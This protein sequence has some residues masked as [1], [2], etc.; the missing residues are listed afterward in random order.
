MHTLQQ[1]QSGKLLGTKAL[2]LSCGL[3]QL[4]TEILDL[5]HTLELLDVSGNNLKDLPEWFTKLSNLK[6]AF[7]SNNDFQEFPAVLGRCPKLEMIGFKA[8]KIRSIP[9]GAIPVN[10]RWLILT[11]NQIATL[12]ASIG[13]CARMQKLMLAGNKL[14]KLPRELASCQNLELL[15]IS[16]NE[17]EQLPEWLFTLPRLSWLAFSGNP[18]NPAPTVANRLLEINWG[19]LE[20]MEQLGEGA[21]G[22]ISKALWHQPDSPTPPQQVAVKVF[23]GEVTSDGLPQDEMQACLASGTHPNLVKVLGKISGHPLQKRGLVFALIPEGYRNLGG[24]PSLETCTRDTFASGTVFSIAEILKISSGIAAAA[25]YLHARGI[26]H[27][28]LYAHN[29]LVNANGHPLFG[30]FGAATVYGSP[31]ATHAEALERI[32]VR[33]FG[34][35]LDDLFTHIAPED[36][37]AA[38]VKPLLQLQQDCL[39]PEILHRPSFATISALLDSLTKEVS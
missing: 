14:G 7:F 15:R 36:A 17:I 1:L 18:C 20:L 31:N 32:E 34:Y 37:S 6:I 26:M 24:P 39:Q 25:R 19:E 12:P 30:D 29:T 22:V 10:T 16:A 2:K 5:A 38:P 33:A 4:P 9:E 21:S 8:C 23:K 11:D 28:D 3:T 13:Q 27:G 35:L